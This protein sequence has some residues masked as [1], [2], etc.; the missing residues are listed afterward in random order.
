MKAAFITVLISLVSVHEFHLSLTEINHNAENRSLEISIKLFT[1]D[2]TTA[3]IQAGASKKIELGT[4]A[5]PPAAN[6][7]V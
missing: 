1:D 5:E 7:L 4:E 2:L 3:L 6:E